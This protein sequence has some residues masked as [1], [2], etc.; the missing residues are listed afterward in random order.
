MKL[1]LL[2]LLSFACMMSYTNVSVAQS[3][4]ASLIEQ[5]E[6]LSKAGDCIACHTK[7]GG[8]KYAGGKAVASPFGAI[9][10]TNITPSV[11]YGIGSYSYKEFEQALRH[12]IRADGEFL[13]PAMPYPDYQKLTDEDTKALYAYFM[14][15]IQPVEKANTKT[16]LGFPFN[17]RWGIRFWNWAATDDGVFV[18][19]TKKSKEYNRGAYLIQGLGHCGSC[20]TPRGMLYQEKAYDHSGDD[21][22]SGADVGIWYAPDLRAGKNGSLES[23]S[24][25]DFV[26]YFA[27]GRNKHSGVTGEM[28]D[29]IQYSLSHLSKDDLRA[30]AVYLKGQAGNKPSKLAS[31]KASEQTTNVLNLAK[32]DIDSGARLYIDNCGACHF[33]D[34]AGASHVFPQLV[35]NS[36]VNADNP[37]GLIHVI[38]AGSRL[39]STADAP[40]AIEMPG[41]GWRLDDEEVAK[42]AT[43]IRDSW[44]NKAKSVNA[45]EVKKIRSTIAVDIL[46]KSAP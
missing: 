19:D 38:L 24:E 3:T 16:A 33:T 11:E 14:K 10:S 25:Q 17:Q 34:G 30:M 41:F 1:P 18:E 8:D 40:E 26:D 21:F 43:F 5:G 45:D 32:V 31:S 9:Y 37:Q 28:T 6:Y 46:N 29:V 13:Y 42:L 36:L 35:G 39:P 27:T 15:G 20:H 44:G 12:G 4:E 22:L 2:S 23:W 7:D